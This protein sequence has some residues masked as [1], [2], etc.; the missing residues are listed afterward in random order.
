MAIGYSLWDHTGRQIW[1]HDRE[2]GDHADGIA[3]VNMS[4]DPNS[5]P[6]VYACGN[7]E[8]F[9]IVDIQGKMLKHVRMGHAQS[10]AIGKFRMDVAG[11]QLLTINYWRNPGI[12]SI[13]DWDGKLVE[14]EEPIHTGSPLLPVNRSE[15]H[16]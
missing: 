7:D 12:I 11:L 15:E 1:S 6:R 4:P 13:F 8:G 16:T 9:I 5:A 14:Q 2:F 10:P 3:I